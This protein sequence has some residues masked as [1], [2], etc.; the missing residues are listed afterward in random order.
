MTWPEVCSSCRVLRFGLETPHRTRLPPLR[1]HSTPP[2]KERRSQGGAGTSF[3]GTSVRISPQH[4][5]RFVKEGHRFLP[6][7]GGGIHGGGW[8]RR[9]THWAERRTSSR[10]RISWNHRG[11]REHRF[12]TINRNRVRPIT[13]LEA[14]ELAPPL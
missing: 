14:E 5:R 13:N 1:R 12:K 9:R 6:V 10:R 7:G 11:V 2:K 4:N 8:I 3:S